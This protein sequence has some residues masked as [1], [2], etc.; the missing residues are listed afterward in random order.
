MILELGSSQ[1]ESLCSLAFEKKSSY[2]VLGL[3]GIVRAIHVLS[4]K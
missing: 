3:L 4:L 1:T 2:C